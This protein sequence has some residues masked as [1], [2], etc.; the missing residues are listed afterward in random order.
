MALV[1]FVDNKYDYFDKNN[2]ILFSADGT[3]NYLFDYVAHD[4]TCLPNLFEQYIFHKIDVSTFELKHNTKS[5]NF[6]YKIKEILESAHPYYKHEFKKTIIMAIGNYFNKLLLYSIYT[7]EYLSL[8]CTLKEQWYYEKFNHLIPFP[9]VRASDYSDGFSPLDF[10][11]RYKILVDEVG[12]NV[13]EIEETFVYN[14]PSK[15]PN[16]FCEELEIQ[17][18]IHNML[19]F[20]LDMSVQNMDELTVSQRIWIYSNLFSGLSDMCV[21]RKLLL[22]LTPL[23]SENNQ[24]TDLYKDDLRDKNKLNNIFCPLKNYYLSDT[25]NSA[26]SIDIMDDAIEY[27]KTINES[28]IYEVYEI[29][30]LQELLTLEV[31]FMIR[32]GLAIKKCEICGKYFVPKT[33]RNKYCERID[34]SGKNCYAIAKK[35]KNKQRL[36]KDPALKLYNTA[37]KTRYAQFK[38]ET[39]NTKAFNAWQYNAR[40]KLDFVR[41]GKLDISEF[42]EWL[43]IT[44]H[45]I[46]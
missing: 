27:A 22:C 15:M 33:K 10:H 45:I 11:H 30:D 2:R 42:Q 43:K 39:I 9:L 37:Y 1:G 18:N 5:I 32:S 40:Q 14:V 31:L 26:V 44:T 7:K 28:Q 24:Q 35:E 25:A 36:E 46:K 20:L 34:G 6:I 13:N 29:S 21:N 3:H 4:L 12:Y 19:Y 16:G 23:P 38:H 41:E 17:K 8:D